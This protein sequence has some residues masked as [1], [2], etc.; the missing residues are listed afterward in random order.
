MTK[1]HGCGF[2]LVLRSPGSV[3]RFAF[4]RD[5]FWTRRFL[6]GLPGAVL[7][8]CLGGSSPRFGQVNRSHAVP[9]A[10][11]SAFRGYAA[12]LR[13]YGCRGADARLCG[14]RWLHRASDFL[15]V[16]SRCR[17]GGFASSLLLGVRE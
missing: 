5:S 17:G 15:S 16:P 4:A 11:P 9:A 13:G 10:R 6:A 3:E 14:R 12:R 8:V 7:W 1:Y 2:G